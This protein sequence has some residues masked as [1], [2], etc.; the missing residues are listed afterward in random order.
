MYATIE[1]DV[2]PLSDQPVGVRFEPR[3]RVDRFPVFVI[4]AEGARFGR[5]R[6]SRVVVRECGDRCA[7][8]AS[9]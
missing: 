7:L 9:S 4:C 5:W 2:P 1:G 3:P 8:D 6:S